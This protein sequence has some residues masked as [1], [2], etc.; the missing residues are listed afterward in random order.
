MNTREIM[1]PVTR[2]MVTETY[3]RDE[4]GECGHCRAPIVR[5]HASNW[6]GR[7]DGMRYVHDDPTRSSGCQFR[8]EHCLTVVDDNWR[9]L[10]PVAAVQS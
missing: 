2:R 7:R 1:H 6:S 9:S 8:C 10:A 5:V 4:P 3:R